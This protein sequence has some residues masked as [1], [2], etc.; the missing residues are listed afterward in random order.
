MHVHNLNNRKP[1]Q[2]L[3][4]KIYG[5]MR[6]VQVASG[7]ILCTDSFLKGG[8]RNGMTNSLVERDRY[9]IERGF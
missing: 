7:H 9:V 1:R 6:C 8:G 5:V 3:F 4:N 2:H